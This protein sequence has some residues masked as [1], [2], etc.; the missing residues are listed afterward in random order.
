MQ[1]CDPGS[2][3][4]AC[5]LAGIVAR[6]PP[7]SGPHSSGKHHRVLTS[8][9]SKFSCHTAVDLLDLVDF[10]FAFPL[11]PRCDTTQVVSAFLLVTLLDAALPSTDAAATT[12]RRRAGGEEVD[13]TTPN[14]LWA[15]DGGDIA[16]RPELFPSL[17]NKLQ[18]IE[19]GRE[20]VDALLLRHF[21]EVR[22]GGS[23]ATLRDAIT[24]AQWLLGDGQHDFQLWRS[25]PSVVT[26]QAGEASSPPP[27]SSV[28]GYPSPFPS[29]RQN[30]PL[31]DALR[32]FIT[33]STTADAQLW[34]HS[35]CGRKDMVSGWL[36]PLAF[37]GALGPEIAGWYQCQLATEQRD[38][39]QEA[40]AVVRSA[41][42]GQRLTTMDRRLHVV[43]VITPVGRAFYQAL[44]LKASLA[45]PKAVAEASIDDNDEPS[46]AVVDKGPA[47]VVATASSAA[48]NAGADGGSPSEPLV[49]D[50]DTRLGESLVRRSSSLLLLVPPAPPASSHARRESPPPTPRRG[51]EDACDPGD[52]VT[53]RMI[54]GSKRLR[55]GDMMDG[56]ESPEED[57]DDDEKIIGSDAAAKGRGWGDVGEPRGPAFRPSVSTGVPPALSYPLPIAA[58]PPSRPSDVRAEAPP[59]PFRYKPPCRYGA[60]CYRRGADHL[61][62]YSHPP[63]LGDAGSPGPVVVPAATP[64]PLLSAPHRGVIEIMPPSPHPTVAA[65]GGAPLVASAA[66][67]AVR[68]VE[69]SSVPPEG[70]L[71]YTDGCAG[72]TGSG[73]KMKFCGGSTYTCSCPVWRYQMRS[74]AQRTC[75][76]LAELLGERFERVRCSDDEDDGE[77]SD[78]VMAPVHVGHPPPGLPAAPAVRRAAS[79]SGGGKVAMPGVLLAQKANHPAIEYTGWWISEKLDGVRA[80]WDGSHMLSRNGNIFTAPDWFVAG[81]P[82]GVTLDGELF[83]GRGMFQTTVGIVKSPA[84]H[85]GW[86][87]LTFE[88]FDVP[89]KG[90]DPFESRVAFL[91]TLFPGGGA[92]AHVH[93][94]D[95]VKCLGRE[96]VTRELA[97][98]EALGGEGLMLRQPASKY[99]NARSSTLLKVK[100]MEE[101]DAIVRGYDPGKGR[102]AGRVGALLA[103]LATGKRFCVGSGMSDAQRLSPPAIGSVIV[104][105]YQELTDAGVP[106]FPVYV[107]V[108][109]DGVWPPA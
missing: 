57:D 80:Y 44:G 35:V 14:A 60:A 41:G 30:R 83:G 82:A 84:S 52:V 78:V 36:T 48:K 5:R 90:G 43:Q 73:Y 99:V 105:R 51:G 47:E 58:A 108:R 109:A 70:E 77:G 91:K 103:E 23:A 102:L 18:S 2:F 63:R 61:A 40:S 54:A 21:R 59:P 101:C 32:R 45:S 10:L 68:G 81:F 85:S 92:T 20:T 96:H 93:V 17:L 55:G 31:C 53:R 69:P 8:F 72:A 75:K 19:A 71:I 42:S 64:I 27:R 106:R 95:H 100:S 9:L 87:S 33:Q 1:S 107:G 50:E 74:P 12:P 89:S 56:F 34:I 94:L 65:R 62:R 15:D 66:S 26:H 98:I 88:I 25:H 6:L 76:H 46:R 24:V 29:L 39:M 13:A 37:L 11:A 49:V 7:A 22:G 16:L 86:R 28:T 4:V 97:R 3:A 104:I 38:R 67:R 79:P